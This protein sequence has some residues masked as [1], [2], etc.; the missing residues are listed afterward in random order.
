MKRLF[1]AFLI[2][3]VLGAG[4]YLFT[5]LIGNKKENSPVKNEEITYEFDDSYSQEAT[6]DSLSENINNE[7]DVIV[8]IG[9][10]EEE[11]TKKVSTLLGDLEMQN[12]NI[13]YLER[14]DDISLSLSYQNLLA[15]YPELNNYMNFTPVILVFRN[16]EFIGGLPGEVEKK[17]LI[18]FL[19]YTEVI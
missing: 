18:H 8:L 17:N 11:P 6:I 12:I 7:E 10:K 4:I 16:K 15:S 13:Y 1:I 2:T 14:Q 19:E 3:L 5:T 9:K